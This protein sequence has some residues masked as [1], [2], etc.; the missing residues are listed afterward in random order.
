VI[1]LCLSQNYGF[2]K[3]NPVKNSIVVWILLIAFTGIATAC[4]GTAPATPTAEAPIVSI[5]P[6]IQVSGALNAAVEANNFYIA[7][8]KGSDQTIKGTMLYLN[9]DNMRIVFIRF[10]KDAQPGTYDIN[11]GFVDENYDGSMATGNYIDSSTGNSQQFAATSGTLTLEA[12]GTTFSGQYEFNAQDDAGSTVT[13]SGTFT[14]LP[15]ETT[16]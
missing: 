10:P 6:T 8:V 4:G 7:P 16:S 3:D 12:T 1:V 9:Q 5:N 15:L 2:A 13:V 14:N 11:Q